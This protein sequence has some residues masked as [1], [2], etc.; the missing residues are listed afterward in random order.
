MGLFSKF[1]KDKKNNN[2]PLAQEESILAPEA[3]KDPAAPEPGSPEARL[4]EKFEEMKPRI[5]PY[6]RPA[7]TPPFIRFETAGRNIDIP[8]PCIPFQ[9][10]TKIFFVE[11]TGS[12]FRILQKT[13]LPESVTPLQLLQISLANLVKNV[14]FE[15]R[16]TVFGGY[17]LTGNPNHIASYIL[18][19]NLWKQIAERLD[20]NLII[21]M[22]VR[23]T[24]MFIPEK[25]KD[26]LLPKLAGVAVTLLRDQKRRFHALTPL[27]F[28]YDRKSERLSTYVQPKAKKD[29]SAPQP[30]PQAEPT[31]PESEIPAEPLQ[32]EMPK[33]AESPDLA[34]EPS[35]RQQVPQPQEEAAP[36]APQAED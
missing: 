22:P 19:K 16:P 24:I 34:Q 25:Q 12:S 8:L 3:K 4:L 7:N 28:F 13:S 30:A 17:G 31:V 14:K 26:E 27:L 20:D 9:A 1:K 29:G 15:M 33:A 36:A 18:I 23:E 6:L 5:Y 21:A 35:G 2:R 10:A 11:D 32:E